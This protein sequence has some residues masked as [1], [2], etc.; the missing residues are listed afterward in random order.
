LEKEKKQ[1]MIST[2]LSNKTRITQET[3]AK[4]ED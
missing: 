2:T 4:S 3:R 1:T